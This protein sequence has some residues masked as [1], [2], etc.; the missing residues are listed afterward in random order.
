MQLQDFVAETITQITQ[1]VITAQKHLHSMGAKVNPT[2]RA[3][4]P[5]GE[6]HFA[7]F[8]WAAGEGGNP[9]LIVNFDVAVTATEET[10][11]KGG[12]GVAVGVVT[13]GTTGAS[14]RGN[15]SASRIVFQVP[16]LLPPHPKTP[17]VP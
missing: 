15:T 10:K 14:D 2:M 16:L 1:G 9:V 4:L 13:L 7:P 8:G 5:K 3:V 12:I 11:T 6:N 17:N